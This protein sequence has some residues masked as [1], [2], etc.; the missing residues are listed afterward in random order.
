MRETTSE[1]NLAWHI[2]LDGKVDMMV[3][4]HTHIQTN[5][6]S[7]WSNGTIFNDVA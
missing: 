7:Y 4:T 2:F 5:D 6:D 1:K 3:G